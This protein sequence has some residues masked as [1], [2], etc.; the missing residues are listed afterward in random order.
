LSRVG[1]APRGQ[2][3]PDWRGSYVDLAELRA[4]AAGGGM[5]V[6][7]LTGEGTQY[8]VALTRNPRGL[9]QKRA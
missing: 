5:D 7:R 8:C 2:L 4:A 9:T 1:R 6:E 3:H